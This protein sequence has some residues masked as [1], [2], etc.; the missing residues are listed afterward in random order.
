M[1]TVNSPPQMLNV[2]VDSISPARVLLA[3]LIA[4]SAISG[5]AVLLWRLL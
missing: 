3:G 2:Q 1:V 5:L 4:L